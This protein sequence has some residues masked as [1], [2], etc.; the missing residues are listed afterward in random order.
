MVIVKHKL[1]IVFAISSS[2]LFAGCQVTK[3]F[4]EG[5]WVKE[6]DVYTT[7]LKYNSPGGEEANKVSLTIKK[8]IITAV[9][10][11]IKTEIKASLKYQGGFAKGL[12]GVIVGKKLSELTDVDKISG[13]S[14][15]TN[16]FNEA[17]RKLKE[18]V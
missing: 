5:P 15:T 17:V 18:Q 8:G 2:F 4:V 9:D 6:G 1:P 11:G 16:A 3:P 14:L 13:A 7:T 10:F 12:T